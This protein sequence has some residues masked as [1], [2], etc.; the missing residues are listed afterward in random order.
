MEQVTVAPSVTV[1]NEPL[2][3]QQPYPVPVSYYY[4]PWQPPFPISCWQLVAY[5]PMP[6]YYTAAAEPPSQAR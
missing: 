5:Y 2:P 4:P 6:S 1:K 3:L